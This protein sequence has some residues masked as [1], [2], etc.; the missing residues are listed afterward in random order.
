MDQSANQKINKLRVEE[1]LDLSKNYASGP[2]ILLRIQTKTADYTCTQADSGTIFTTY[3][4]TG[5]ITFT[6]PTN[7]TKGW[8]ALFFQSVDQDITITNATVDT[9]IT[10]NDLAADGVAASTTSHQ[11]GAFF[12]VFADGNVFNAVN[13]GGH[14]LTVNT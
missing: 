9:L 4:D 3:G 12:L 13:L 8:F 10:Y 5:A 14:T 6:L 11:I 2:K 1:L 7:P